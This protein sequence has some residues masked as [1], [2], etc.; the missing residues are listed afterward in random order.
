[1]TDLL[2][3]LERDS[4]SGSLSVSVA[5]RLVSLE[6]SAID[7][8]VVGALLAAGPVSS[9]ALKGPGR[10]TNALWE[11]VKTELRKFLCTDDQ[12]YADLREEWTGLKQKGS[13]IAVGALSGAIGAKLGVASGVLA[14][15][16]I[17]ILM[18]AIRIGKNGLCA[19]LAPPAAPTGPSE[20]STS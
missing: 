20:A 8:N 7:W 5:K 9:V 19:A 4:L 15:M 1:M 11:N 13:G 3:G 6:T 10:W 18:V 16:V 14:P 12:E 17:W 2:A